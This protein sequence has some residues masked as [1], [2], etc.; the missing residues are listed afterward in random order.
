MKKKIFIVPITWRLTA[1]LEIEA[2][3]KDEAVKKAYEKIPASGEY[4]DDSLHVIQEDIQ[5]DTGRIV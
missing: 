4:V 3:D 5:L 2:K 1:N